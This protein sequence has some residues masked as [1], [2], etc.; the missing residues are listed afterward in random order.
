MFFRSTAAQIKSAGLLKP[1]P[2]PEIN[3]VQENHGQI[4]NDEKIPEVGGPKKCDTMKVGD[5][6]VE[7]IQQ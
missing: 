3:I 6:S 7:K 5:A 1:G 2:P 4:K